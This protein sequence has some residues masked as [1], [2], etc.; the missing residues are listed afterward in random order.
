LDCRHLEN[1]YELFL[2]G[3]LQEEGTLEL[4]EH[5]AQGCG[6][7]LERV[8]EATRT[9][10]LLSLTAKPVSPRPKAKD[11]LVRMVKGK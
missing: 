2:L 8:R 9:V 5:L 10:Y 4:C 3:A 6:N 7:C 11:D 1:I